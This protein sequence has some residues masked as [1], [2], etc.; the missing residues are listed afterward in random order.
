M[1]IYLF[2][3]TPTIEWVWA[4]NVGGYG[5]GIHEARAVVES[6]GQAWLLSL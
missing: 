4:D 2:F 3:I 5:G 6:V 1:L